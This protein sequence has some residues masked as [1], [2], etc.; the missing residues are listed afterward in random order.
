MPALTKPVRGDRPAV[1]RF[2]EA[3]RDLRESAPAGRPWSVD[4]AIRSCGKGVTRAAV[5]A[6]LSGRA[7]P[8][9]NTLQLI[10]T[11]W[12]PNG[13][14]D[15]PHW[16]ARRAAC[17]RELGGHRPEQAPSDRPV[18]VDGYGLRL[19]HRRQERGMSLTALARELNYSKGYLSKIENGM[20][21]ASLEFRRAVRRLLDLA[22]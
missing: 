6:A 4:E 9:R 14:R 11:A 3:L 21:P 10:V 12:A 18:L 8:S 20:R 17:E 13:E 2:A 19:K 15:L 5:Y 7:L 1:R 16:M 22:E